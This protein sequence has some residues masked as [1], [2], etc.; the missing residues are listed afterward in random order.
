MSAQNRNV[1]IP[2]TVGLSIYEDSE[3]EGESFKENDMDGDT[4]I[5][6][7]LYRNRLSIYEESENEGDSFE[8]KNGN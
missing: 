6:L 1:K 5:A 7:L 2:R 3:N 8:E 4:G